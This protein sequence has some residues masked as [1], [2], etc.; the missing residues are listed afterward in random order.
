[1]V[2]GSLRPPEQS[3]NFAEIAKNRLRALGKLALLLPVCYAAAAICK[4]EEERVAFGAVWRKWAEASHTLRTGRK[5][6]S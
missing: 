5:P 4:G 3:G 2:D 6:E 1:M